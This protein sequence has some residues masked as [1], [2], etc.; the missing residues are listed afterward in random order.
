M[1]SP[2]NVRLFFLQYV[3]TINEEKERPSFYNT[4]T[5]NC[6]NVIW[7]HASIFPDRPPFSWKLLAS[8]YSSEY[9]YEMGRLDTSL[10]FAELTRQGY[11][12]PVAQALG[13]ST[14][15]SQ[16]IRTE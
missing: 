6:T 10:P 9:L 2:E 16:R 11:I 12:N 14:D 5:A 8:G 15:F 4:L 1:V 7:K 3:K 13:D